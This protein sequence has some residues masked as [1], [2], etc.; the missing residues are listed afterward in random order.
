MKMK[1]CSLDVAVVT[2]GKLKLQEDLAFKAEVCGGLEVTLSF[3]SLS[4]EK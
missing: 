4:S 3:T 1:D 2:L